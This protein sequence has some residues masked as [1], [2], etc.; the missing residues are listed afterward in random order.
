M[1][2]SNTTTSIVR[3]DIGDTPEFAVKLT[4]RQRLDTILRRGSM[5]VHEVSTELDVDANSI[6]KTVQ[7]NPKRFILLEGGRVGLRA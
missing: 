7:R 1:T 6:Y 3:A 2:F 5:P 4:I